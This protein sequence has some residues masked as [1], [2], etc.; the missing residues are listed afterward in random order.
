M[1]VDPRELAGRAK[2]SFQEVIDTDR[3]CGRCGYNLKGLPAGGRCPECGTA[4]VRGNRKGAARFSDNLTDAPLYYL[5]TLAAG[6]WMLGGGVGCIV[7]MVLWEWLAVFRLVRVPNSWPMVV[8]ATFGVASLMWWVGVYIC[9]APRPVS[10]RTLRDAM[11]ESV[12]LRWVN[13]STQAAW[14]ASAVAFFAGERLPA[15]QDEWAQWASLAFAIIGVLGVIPLA[16]QFSSLAEWAGDTDLAGKFRV[17][18]S[19][20]AICGGIG[21]LSWIAAKADL[22]GFWYVIRI[23]GIWARL[24]M[25]IAEVWLVVAL[26]QFAHIASWAIS[27]SL[28]AQE[29]SARIAARAG[30]PMAHHTCPS[31]GY[32][33]SGLS[34]FDR[35]PECGHLEESVRQSG[36][37]GLRLAG[38]TPDAPGLEVPL[39]EKG[40]I[41]LVAE[42][43]VEKPK[44]ASPP[45]IG[46]GRRWGEKGQGERGRGAAGGDHNI[47]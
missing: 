11:L 32:D 5:K 20:L 15:P 26:Y 47:V 27:N 7:L 4:I 16:I 12:A 41:P 17:C 21:V 18:A 37:I 24:G 33:M 35:C 31:C 43:R 28:T 34:A 8:A 13:R 30:D 39:T 1:P 9:T 25:G 29:V 2:P 42:S 10:E 45:P 14:V 22:G 44:I 46:V 36:L 40:E 38:H 6:T 19:I 3:P 23:L